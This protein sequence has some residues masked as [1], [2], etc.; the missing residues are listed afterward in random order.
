MLDLLAF[1]EH[2]RVWIYPSDRF[3]ADEFI[4]EIHY[5]IKKFTDQWIS[6]SQ[7][8]KATG[9]ILHNYFIVILVDEILNKPGGC[10]IDTSVRFVQGIGDRYQVNFFNRQMFHYIK[11]EIV[12]Q[13]PQHG[14]AHKY[15]N[16]IIDDNTLFFD[17]LVNNKK[18]FIK[19][20]LKPYSQS[21][22]KKLM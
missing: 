5:D 4:P 2:S 11:D 7:D 14:L 9:G 20:W 16:G 15:T 22:H 12:H 8:L 3:I 18:D 17:P 13:I 21:W 19:N 1:P 10:S 6:H